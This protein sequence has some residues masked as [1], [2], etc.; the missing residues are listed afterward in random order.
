VLNQILQALF[1]SAQHFYEKRKGSRAGSGSIPRLMDP[2]PDPRG[3][4]TCRSCGSVSGS[5]SGSPTL[6]E[7]LFFPYYTVYRYHPLEKQWKQK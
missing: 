5:G 1:Q 4:K 6:L 7:T 2:D 3:P